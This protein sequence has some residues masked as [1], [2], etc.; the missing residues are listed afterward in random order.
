VIAAMMPFGSESTLPGV[1]F[2]AEKK[3]IGCFYG[4]TRQWVGMVR[5]LNFYR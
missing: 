3:M 5:L 2:L 1:A 4:S